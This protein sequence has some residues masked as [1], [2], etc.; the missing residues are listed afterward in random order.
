MGHPPAKAKKNFIQR[1][2]RDWTLIFLLFLAILGPYYE[3]LPY[4]FLNLDD[5]YYVCENPYIR[6]LS[7]KGTYKIF[8]RPLVDN[9]FP[10]QILSYALDYQI[11]HIQPFGY[12]LHNVVLHILNAA[13]IFLLL[14]K[15][16][17]QTWISFFTALLFG[18]HPVNVESVTWIAERKNVLSMALLLMSF[19]AYL[20]YLEEER[21]GRKKGFY[22]GALFLFLLALLAKASAVVLP[23]L[24]WLFDVCFHKRGKWRSVRDKLPFLA[25]AGLFS[26]IEIGIYCGGGYL[27]GYHGGSPYTTFLA[28]VNVLVEYLISL[29]VPINL[30]HLYWTRIPRTF[31][32]RQVLLSFAVILLL[33][34]LAWRSFRGNRVFFFW[35][36]WFL[37]SLLPVLNIVPLIILRADRYMYLPAIGFFYLISWTLWKWCRGK[38]GLYRLPVLLSCCFFLAG[39]YGL[40]TFERNKLWR[41]PIVFWEE[42][43]K[44]FPQSATPVKYI[45]NLYMQRGKNDLA[46]SYFQGG[47]REN[48][49]EV[50]LLNGLA[51]AYKNK[52]QLKKAETILLKAN[53][54]HPKDSGTYNNLGTV[55]Y[56]RG[57]LE[58]S[59]SSLIHALAMDPQN[60]S[61][62]AN[63]GVILCS[64]NRWDEAVRE[65][66]TARELSPGSPEPYL[67]LAMVYE[68]ER[69][70][71][72]AESCLKKALDY[73][74][75]SHP[76]LFTLGRVAYEQGKLS[77]AKV[78][79]SHAR[80]ILQDHRDTQLFLRL[81][82]QETMNL[83]SPSAMDGRPS[84]QPKATEP[85][86]KPKGDPGNV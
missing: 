47:L 79:F 80:R 59:R 67:N 26:L 44:K 25:L 61:A 39:A 62:R 15:I 86:K 9:Y 13:L 8:S 43:L 55:Y 36:G 6:D 11:W 35:A 74:P 41:D 69:R 23:L 54:L 30:D 50:T 48:P 4:P 68:R 17:S 60:A 40:L 85:F 73:V 22:L 66:E 56:Q 34:I 46:I 65:F 10:L 21:P 49:D 5:P 42:S 45:G 76:V 77:E 78:Y 58:K 70:W 52:G 18:L 32:D 27:A 83:R 57:E 37:I 19:L 24:L 71:D 33:G 72:K 63:L 20:Y 12:R 7:W 38:S 51:I 28:M 53:R 2:P 16:F 64:L 14:K 29:I 3:S 81:I 82:D 84:L 1:I 31:F 75:A